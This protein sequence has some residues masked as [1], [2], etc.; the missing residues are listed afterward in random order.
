MTRVFIP[1]DAQAV[2]LGADRV[3]RSVADWAGAK[4]VDITI[5][6]TGS[7]G[8]FWLEPTIEVETPEGRLAYGPVK[9]GD[10]DGLFRAGLLQGEST[11]CGWAARRTSPT[12]HV[13]RASPLRAAASSIR[14]RRTITRPMADIPGWRAPSIWTGPP[15]STR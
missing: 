15:S 13:R 5:V 9:P 3:A 14:S 8:L 7:R 2:A 12:W 6:R 4:D 1:A 10:V 11:S